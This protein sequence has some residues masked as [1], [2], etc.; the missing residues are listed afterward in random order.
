MYSTLEQE[1]S[2]PRRNIRYRDRNNSMQY[3][4]RNW[5]SYRWVE[6]VNLNDSR[7]NFFKK[8]NNELFLLKNNI[9]IRIFYWLLSPSCATQT[10][11]HR[12]GMFYFPQCSPQAAPNPH[13]SVLTPIYWWLPTNFGSQAL[14]VSLYGLVQAEIL[15]NYQ[16]SSPISRNLISLLFINLVIFPLFQVG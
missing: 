16:K 9:K 10:L 6:N 13:L 12:G 5:K 3:N 7:K 1:K 15:Q 8:D 4:T 11:S 2:K 14:S